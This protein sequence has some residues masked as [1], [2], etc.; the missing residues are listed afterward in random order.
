M[1]SLDELCIRLY[2]DAADLKSI[3]VWCRHPLIRGLTTNP[4]LMRKAGILNYEEFSRQVLHLVPHLPVSIEVFADDLEGMETQARKIASWGGN[5]YVKIPVTNTKGEST[6]TLI[7]KLSAAGI[8]VNVTAVMTPEQVET[9]AKVLSPDV[10]AVVSVFAG[11]VADTGIDPVPIMKACLNILR[12]L[13]LTQLLWA[14]PRELLN[15]FQA[16]EIGVHIITATPD[17]LAKLPIIG[18]DLT[19]YSLETVKMF[20]EDASKAGYTL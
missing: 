12:P 10:P 15:I 11:R 4:T 13:P 14:S 9:I 17:I 16:D 7:E 5:A 6:S 19:N 18:N 3:T 20:Y 2:V 8:A 1:P